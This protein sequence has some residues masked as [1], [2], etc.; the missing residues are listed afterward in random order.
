MYYVDIYLHNSS[1]Y[2]FASSK[3]SSGPK[4]QL[5]KKKNNVAY[6]ATGSKGT[7]MV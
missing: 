2:K 6:S 5:T 7:S 1:L 4:K 3:P